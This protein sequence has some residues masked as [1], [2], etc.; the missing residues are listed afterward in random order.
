MTRNIKW[1]VGLSDGSNKQSDKGEFK[2]VKGELSP[3]Q[4]LLNYIDKKG[5]KITSLAL[6]IE[7]K[8]WNLPSKGNQPKFRAFDEAKSPNSYR[9]FRKMGVDILNGKKKDV[10]HYAVAEA[11]YNNKKLQIWVK[12]KEP[13]PSWSIVLNNKKG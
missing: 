9:F 7:G 10:E 6:F 3:W 4:K 1:T 5:L 13:Y 2:R 8:R 11:Q 12:D